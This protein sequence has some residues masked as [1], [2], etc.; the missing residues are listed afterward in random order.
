VKIRVTHLWQ[1]TKQAAGGVIFALTGLAALVMV[2]L[3]SRAAQAQTLPGPSVPAG[4]DKL[5]MQL[6]F[7]HILAA[8][9]QQSD[10]A[11]LTYQVKAGQSMSSIADEQCHGQARDWTGIYA[12]SRAAH[13]TGKNANMISTGQELAI[14]CQYLPSQL[15]YADPP[16]QRWHP[17]QAVLSASGGHRDQFDGNTQYGCGDGDGDGAHDMPC[18]LLHGGGSTVIHR[19]VTVSSGGGMGNVNPH[20]YSG[21]QQCVITRESGGNSQV[22][23][24]S[25]HY[26]LYQFSA[27]TWQAY[28][29]SASSFGH[30]SASY[31]TQIFNNAMAQGGQNN[32]SP[33]DGC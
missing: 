12:A 27:S 7:R 18:S 25:G 14:S 29:G 22:M 30:A 24:S 1:V 3:P 16:Q 13:L 15:K 20:N 8:T 26:G 33:Y 32:W 6:S 23:N 17:Q 4:P 9:R 31:Q 5:A 21:F 11:L 2:F 28:G 19:A 10:A